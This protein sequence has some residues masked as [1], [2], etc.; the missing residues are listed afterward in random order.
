MW[1]KDI[2]YKN[3]TVRGKSTE[4]A[5]CDTCTQLEEKLSN[6]RLSTEEREFYQA[7]LLKHDRLTRAER[8]AYEMRKR[9]AAEK[10]NDI[11]SLAL[12]GGDQGAYGTP[13]FH[14]KTKASDKWFKMRNYVVGVCIHNRGFPDMLFH[15]LPIFER[16]ANCTID[17]L[18]QVFTYVKEK[19]GGRELPRKL[20]LQLDN[21]S[22]ENKNKYLLAF[23]CDLVWKKVFDEVYISYLP[24]GHTHFDPDA[25]FSCISGELENNH[26]LS[27]EELLARMESS[28]QPSPKVE[29][30]HQIAN[31]SDYIDEHELMKPMVGLMQVGAIKIYRNTRRGELEN[32]PAVTTR[33]TSSNPFKDDRW[34]PPVF[35]LKA[36]IDYRQIAYCKFIAMDEFKLKQINKGI[37]QFEAWMVEHKFC[38]DQRYQMALSSLRQCFNTVQNASTALVP[39]QWP[40]KQRGKLFYEPEPSVGIQIQQAMVAEEERDITVAV[41]S[42]DSLVVTASPIKLCRGKQEQLY[43]YQRRIDEHSDSAAFPVPDPICAGKFAVFIKEGFEL[44]KK[45]PVTQREFKVGLVEKI[46]RFKYL[47]APPCASHLLKDDSDPKCVLVKW[48]DPTPTSAHLLFQDRIYKPAYRWDNEQGKLPVR[49]VICA[50]L[51]VVGFNEFSNTGKLKK[52]TYEAVAVTVESM[53]LNPER[54]MFQ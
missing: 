18:H 37:N 9:E 8:L 36:K 54:W 12:D 34:S 49:D 24:K 26:A 30:M 1:K 21:C 41:M 33:E 32:H 4:F 42:S 46:F 51:A 7:E 38:T 29:R 47:K 17:V 45:M 16:G 31:I 15:H 23:L 6:R 25:V 52:K 22:R 11:L 20:F 14:Q 35:P 3:V 13:Y 44:S 48:Y 50:S 19:R 28:K 5:K 43:N 2:G 27:V 10:P 53:Y 39:F 40:L